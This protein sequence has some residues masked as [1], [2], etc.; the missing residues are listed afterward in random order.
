MLNLLYLPWADPTAC[1][2]SLLS[3]A[4]L[5]LTGGQGWVGLTSAHTR[6]YPGGAPAG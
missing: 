5:C 6:G 3:P 1:G 2:V 4:L